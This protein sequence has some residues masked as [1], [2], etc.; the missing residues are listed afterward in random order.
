M[1]QDTQ[2]QDQTVALIKTRQWPKIIITGGI[3]AV[4]GWLSLPMLSQWQS[5]LTLVEAEQITTAKVIRGTLVRDIAV[6]GRLV[7]ANAPVL[8][9]P[10]QGQV[11]L[12]VKPGDRVKRNDLLATV[13]SPEL[14]AQIKQQ[15][16]TLDSLKIAASR[17]QLADSEAQLDL[18]RSVD[19]AQVR[20]NAE[21]RE[22]TRASLS[23]QKQ[24]IS[25]LDFAK[26][27]DALLEADLYY[28]HAL[29]R[30]DL[31]TRRLS[32]ENQTRQKAVQSQVLLLS[33]LQ[34][35]Q[36][37]LAILAPVS[38]IVGNALVSQQELVNE[39]QALMSIVD[40]SQYE[41]QINVP[42]FYADDLAIGLGVKMSLA[43]KV[44]IGQVISISPEIHNNQVPIKVSINSD[45]GLNLRQNQ[46]LT[47]RIEFESKDNV[48]MI[49]RG[50]FL[51]SSAGKYAYVMN[52]SI[53]SRR[54]ITTGSASVEFIELTAGVKEGDTLVT[55][56]YKD[57][58]QEQ[59][60]QLVN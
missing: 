20:L 50:A 29:K 40:L 42:E 33:E 10:A 60:I 58:N 23:Y 12:L 48:L 51:G 57:F 9:S 25:E 24:V 41:A 39:T 34:R 52:D 21:K 5:G 36:D 2:S 59:Q 3:L 14:E 56:D 8:Y 37:A 18:Q 44:L 47:A 38:G 19:S 1:I 7:A 45:V 54:P 11:T 31:A 32:F 27:K 26:R 13:R 4:V 6:S 22:H 28:K 53:A 30:I 55:S 16:A 35:Q 17:G 15:E 43:G 46:R 49:K